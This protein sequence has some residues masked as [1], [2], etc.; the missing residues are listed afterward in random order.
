M[1]ISYWLVLVKGAERALTEVTEKFESE[2]AEAVADRLREPGVDRA[3]FFARRWKFSAEV[4]AEMA[5]KAL[6][7]TEALRKRLCAYAAVMGGAAEAGKVVADERESGHL[8][9]PEER[10]CGG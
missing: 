7:E 2:A 4:H 5:R 3:L 6:D 1:D 8:T 9:D 10:R